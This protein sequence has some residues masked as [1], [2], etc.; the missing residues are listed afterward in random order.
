VDVKTMWNGVV[1]LSMIRL[2]KIWVAP[3]SAFNNPILGVNIQNVFITRN[4]EE[5]E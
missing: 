4:K 3:H 1:E 2:D 5:Y